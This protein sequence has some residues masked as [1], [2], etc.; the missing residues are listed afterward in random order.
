MNKNIRRRVLIT[1]TFRVNKIKN[2]YLCIII[3][4]IGNSKTN[5][6]LEI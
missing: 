4:Y 2:Q 6:N 1:I 5:K 3:C